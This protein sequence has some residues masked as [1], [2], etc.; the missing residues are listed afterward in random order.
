MTDATKLALLQ[1]LQAYAKEPVTQVDH[2]G[3]ERQVERQQANPLWIIDL[4]ILP[5]AERRSLLRSWVVKGKA[6]RELT[7]EQLV[8]ARA[9]QDAQLDAQITDLQADLTV[10][11]F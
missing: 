4:L 2:Q 5:N 7:R 6:D 11:G 3:A 8:A 10:G 1:Q 9:Q